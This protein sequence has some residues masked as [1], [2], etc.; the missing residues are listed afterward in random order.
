M[1]TAAPFLTSEPD[2]SN[3]NLI[4]R[5]NHSI[6]QPRT[7]QV[8]NSPNTEEDGR[9]DTAKGK[10]EDGRVS[11]IK[12]GTDNIANLFGVTT[13]RSGA[14][15]ASESRSLFLE[16]HTGAL[17]TVVNVSAVLADPLSLPILGRL[18]LLLGLLGSGLLVAEHHVQAGR[19]LDG[20]GY[21]G[22]GT[23]SSGRSKRTGS[24]KEEDK[25]KN[26]G[27]N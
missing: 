15:G 22:R 20:D 6:I 21:K 14:L 17:G 11:A 8:L 1:A 4:Q 25:G 16:V 5:Y 23:S 18:G 9:N 3:K 26:G 13:A 10:D 27:D 12:G 24:T 2:K 7:L 19:A